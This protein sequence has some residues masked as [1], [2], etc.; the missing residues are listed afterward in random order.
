LTL[1]AKKLTC[2]G[3]PVDNRGMDAKDTKW[4]GGEPILAILV[5]VLVLAPAIYVASLGPAVWLYEHQYVAPRV[6][7]V[8]YW[9]LELLAQ[10]SPAA[11]DLLEWY[12]NLFRERPL[13]TVQ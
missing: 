12:G 1:A 8:V 10:A 9:P 6:L 3:L 5:L 2:S 4:S 7:V 11:G 13:G